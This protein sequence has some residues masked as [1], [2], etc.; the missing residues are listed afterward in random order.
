MW[1]LHSASHRASGHACAFTALVFSELSVRKKVLA[2]LSGRDYGELRVPSH[3]WRCPK[4]HFP[5]LSWLPLA[6]PPPAV[7]QFQRCEHFSCPLGQHLPPGFSSCVYYSKR[8]HD[9]SVIKTVQLRAVHAGQA[10]C[11]LS[12]ALAL[13]CLLLSRQ[14]LS[15]M[16]L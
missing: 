8:I 6:S 15:V 9:I 2:W 16:Q 1:F 4:S 13:L 7:T 3:F 12:P 10:F 11:Q 14:G 5:L